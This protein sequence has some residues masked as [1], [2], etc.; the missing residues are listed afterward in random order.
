MLAQHLA[1]GVKIGVASSVIRAQ[2]QAAEIYPA[3]NAAWKRLVLRVCLPLDKMPAVQPQAPPH[4]AVG[5]P[6]AFRAPGLRDCQSRGQAAD[7]Q[8]AEEGLAVSSGQK[9]HR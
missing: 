2:W 7:R 6:A 1:R 4:Q 5:A 9:D 3:V 8:A